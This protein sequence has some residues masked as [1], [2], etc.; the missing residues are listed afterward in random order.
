[1]SVKDYKVAIIGAGPSGGIL[2]AYLAQKDVDVTLVDIWKAHMK[3]IQKDGLQ[4]SGAST[5]VGEFD[6]SN[7]KTSITELKDPDLVFIAVKTSLLERVAS[8]LKKVVSDNTLVVSHQNGIGTEDYLAEVFGEDK[9]FRFV[10]NYAG[11]I[12]EPGKIDM[13]FFNPPNY[14]GSV[15]PDNSSITRSIAEMITN[16][17]L[18]TEFQGNILPAVWKKAILNAAL[19][20]I[21]AVTHMTMR[22]A[23]DFQDTYDVVSSIIKEGVVVANAI[24]I[25]FDATFYDSAI[26]YLSK[27]GHHKPSTLCDVEARRPTEVDRLNAKIAEVGK[28]NSIATPY[29][30]SV[31][32]VIRA[33]DIVNDKKNKIIAEGI[34]NLGLEAT[35]RECDVIESCVSSFKYCPYIGNPI[36]R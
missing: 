15:S 7:L 17:G 14:I 27:G 2:G 32:A 10:I 21:C 24:G 5:L 22:E 28:K 9:A 19:G 3:A 35:C 23:M 18:T 26:A 30:D 11:N 34:S 33:L 16:S 12:L 8:D 4:I 20:G 31:A 36:S 1:L 6:A 13:T 25:A 29:N